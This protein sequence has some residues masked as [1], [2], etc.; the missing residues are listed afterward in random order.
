MMKLLTSVAM[1]AGAIAM[2]ASARSTPLSDPIVLQRALLQQL[3]DASNVCF[4]DLGPPPPEDYYRQLPKGA[5]DEE[6][7]AMLDEGDRRRDTDAAA[8]AWDAKNAQCEDLYNK[9][10]EAGINLDN[11]CRVYPLLT[12]GHDSPA[13]AA[14]LQAIDI[15]KDAPYTEREKPRA[16]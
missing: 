12:I 5:T 3:G 6:V 4:T 8:K 9:V 15:C 11:M 2:P 1:L 16:K 7:T 14:D 10:L 13:T